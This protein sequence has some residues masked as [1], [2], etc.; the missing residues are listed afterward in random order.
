MRPEASLRI[1]CKWLRHFT[2]NPQEVAWAS[3]VFS[4]SLTLLLVLGCVSD[5]RSNTQRWSGLQWSHA[6]CRVV[7]AGL[8]YRGD[9]TVDMRPEYNYSDCNAS[10]QEVESSCQATYREA[11]HL[12]RRGRRLVT[13]S[14]CIN[15]F[16]PWAS[17]R[18]DLQGSRLG[19]TPMSPRHHL[20]ATGSAEKGRSF[21]S[22]YTGSVHDSS[23]FLLSEAKQKAWNLWLDAE[24][25]R[26]IDCWAVSLT[27]EGHWKDQILPQCWVVAWSD[28]SGWD[29]LR[30]NTSDWV[31]VLLLSFT[32]LAG[33]LTALS[34]A[35]LAWAIHTEA[36]S[37][38]DVFSLNQQEL[39]NAVCAPAPESASARMRRVREQWASFRGTI[40][41]EYGRLDS[42]RDVVPSPEHE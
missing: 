32:F 42:A 26:K 30:N 34:I 36:R 8:A 15:K 41:A 7:G 12:S 39:A 5:R 17:V 2:S 19:T 4:T 18:V 9:C 29:E 22:Y 35:S 37:W 10:D 20:E 24:S 11:Y 16:L 25:S 23:Y 27:R 38:D 31:H 40:L 33:L 14:P 28:P 21:C 6:Q 1:C 3:T 13:G